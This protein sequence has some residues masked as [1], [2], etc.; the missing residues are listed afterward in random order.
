MN[1]LNFLKHIIHQTATCLKQIV[2][3][4][5]SLRPV[6]GMISVKDKSFAGYGQTCNCIVLNKKYA[7][8]YIDGKYL[9][10]VLDKKCVFIQ[11]E[12][13]KNKN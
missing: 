8:V 1:L 3:Y 11:S 2:Y 9:P 13:F 10:F 5:K 12:L 7:I 4:I 6:R